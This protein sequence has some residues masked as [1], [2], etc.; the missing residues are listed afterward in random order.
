MLNFLKEAFDSEPYA[1]TSTWKPPATEWFVF[2]EDNGNKFR[3]DITSPSQAGAGDMGKRVK[4]VRIGQNTGGTNYKAVITKFKDPRKVIATMIDIMSR[5]REE[6]KFGQKTDG[7]AFKFDTKAFGPY[8]TLVKKILAQKLMKQYSVSDSN[9]SPDEKFSYVYMV[10]KG[11]QFKDVF[12]GSVF[13]DQVFSNGSKVDAS[14][15]QPETEQSD[16]EHKFKVGDSFTI[17]WEKDRYYKVL[18]I[19]G[20]QYETDEFSIK[21]NKKL[22][23]SPTYTAIVFAD[24]NAT[25]FIID[26]SG[27]DIKYK[28]GDILKPKVGN[29]KEYLV[30]KGVNP[31]MKSYA[32]EYFNI[33]TGESVHTTTISFIYAN[34]GLTQLSEKPAPDKVYPEV[35][36]RF[37]IGDWFSFSAVDP[38]LYYRVLEIVGDEYKT[39]KYSNVQGKLVSDDHKIKIKEADLNAYDYV[40]KF[41]NKFKVGDDVMFASTGGS[42]YHKVVG[43]KDGD[44]QFDVYSVETGE[45]MYANP[46]NVDIEYSDKTA[47]LYK[48]SK[49]EEEPK[50]RFKVADAIVMKVPASVFYIVTAVDTQMMKYTLAEYKVDGN[51]AGKVDK[52][53]IK[54]IDA[55]AT[56]YEFTTPVILGDKYKVGDA[57][58]IKGIDL[59]YY[60]VTGVTDDVYLLQTYNLDDNTLVSSIETPLSKKYVEENGIPKTDVVKADT[61]K[62]EEVSA[63]DLKVG[64][65]I[66]LGEIEENAVIVSVVDD[67]VYLEHYSLEGVFKGDNDIAIEDLQSVLDTD[68]KKIDNPKWSHEWPEYGMITEFSSKVYTEKTSEHADYT[69]KSFKSNEQTFYI[70]SDGYIIKGATLIGNKNPFSITKFIQPITE[71]E[72]KQAEDTYFE[73]LPFEKGHYVYV[74]SSVDSPMKGKSG[75]IVNI[76]MVTGVLKY[77]IEA[78][79]VNGFFDADQFTLDKTKSIAQQMKAVAK[80]TATKTDSTQDGTK[81][82]EAVKK[83]E[84]PADYHKKY[85][86]IISEATSRTVKK[87]LMGG[88]VDITIKYNNIFEVLDKVPKL[89]GLDPEA[90]QGVVNGMITL[91][92]KMGIV[93]S[94]ADNFQ[95]E[96]NNALSQD[97]F[98]AIFSYTGSGYTSINSYFRT[99]EGSDFTKERVAKIDELYAKLGVRLSN[100]VLYRGQRTDMKELE[101]LENGGTLC[102]PT[103]TSTSLKISIA[104]AFSKASD[105]IHSAIGGTSVQS[106]KEQNGRFPAVFQIEKLENTLALPILGNS[107]FEEEAEI[108]LN[109]ATYVK[110][111]SDKSFVT[112]ASGAKFYRVEVIGEQNLTEADK[113]N[114]LEV[115]SFEDYLKEREKNMEDKFDAAVAA[116]ADEIFE[117]SSIPAEMLND[118]KW[119]D[120]AF[121]VV[122]PEGAYLLKD[123]SGFVYGAFD[124][125][126]EAALH[127]ERLGMKGYVVVDNK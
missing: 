115:K 93:S 108:I 5:Y 79:G 81:V 27:T 63:F 121:A 75:Q 38:A 24:S 117:P 48:P 101:H 74:K 73:D 114:M 120:D 116:V 68:G 51:V 35:P 19:V 23:D 105:D 64:D 122:N 52:F 126:I 30:V 110:L 118:P 59:I 42:Y 112:L 47:T 86:D 119:N 90:W 78:D 97:H 45:K 83:S 94:E 72:F 80:A 28:V 107:K 49:K 102:F 40:P 22:N 98:D 1:W 16:V 124:D 21:G 18:K 6:G 56:P 9:F 46:T 37:K 13:H 104:F 11:K 99:G 127:A 53:S 31:V 71:A 95:S 92:R 36:P 96:V 106:A 82:K 100:S 8:Q 65:W 125:K 66:G 34:K 123:S 17:P 70:S 111:V 84:A 54:S 89:K 60:I 44:Y 50:H 58:M 43:I 76:K 29:D 113:S 33:K 57:L 10:R 26:T 12:N 62:A 32:V 3:L 91:D 87:E 109:R 61:A 15:K 7:F 2:E 69:V 77:A 25:A 103:Y 55:I 39:E 4:V 67:I 41:K 20:D 88:L 14:E 85:S